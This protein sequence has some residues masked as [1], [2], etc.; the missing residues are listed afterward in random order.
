M[1][2]PKTLLASSLHEEA[3]PGKLAGLRNAFFTGLILLA[4]LS[5]TVFVVNFLLTSIGDPA[6]DVFF[7][8]LK[9]E[10]SNSAFAS[11]VLA[12]ISM[13]IVVVL[14]TVLGYASHY[15]FGRWLFRRAEGIIL[16]VPFVNIVYRTTKQIV[17][18]FRSQNK[19]MFQKVVMVEFPRKG[20]YTIGFLTNTTE[21]EIRTH[22]GQGFVNVFVPTTPV[23]TAG[24]LIMCPASD[25]IELEMSV[26]DAMKLIISGGVVVPPH[27]TSQNDRGQLSDT[28]A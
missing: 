16:R 11:Y 9:K 1:P 18:T 21:G 12:L 14:I 28:E 23:P 27:G 22:T 20:A 8:W 13:V 25:V 5:V 19:A 17:E 3:P 26:P 7:G 15:L 10:M 4:P 6:S 24:F 2:E